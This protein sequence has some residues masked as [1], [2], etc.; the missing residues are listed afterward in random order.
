MA[1]KKCKGESLPS[2]LYHYTNID[3][4]EQILPSKSDDIKDGELYMTLRL[5]HPKQCN[6]PEEQNFFNDTLY[7]DSEIC[8]QLKDN[9]DTTKE[10]I[11][12]PFI[13]SLIRHK[14]AIMSKCPLTEIPMWSMYGKKEKGVRLR[15]DYKELNAYCK[16]NN[17]SLISCRYLNKEGMRIETQKIR[18]ENKEGKLSVDRL[19]EIYKQ[20]ILYKPL[21]WNYECEHRIVVWTN[22]YLTNEDNNR[23]VY[24]RIPL[25]ILKVIQISPMANVEESKK[26]INKMKNRIQK[27]GFKVNLKVETSNILIK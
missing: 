1:N 17:F 24:I 25:S 10:N 16:E 23:Y 3:A 6:D 21:I 22:N 13:M 14:R 11:G 4:L 9:V 18:D 26:A 27:L 15:F 19:E 7:R 2:S 5:S 8:K 20:S 12:E